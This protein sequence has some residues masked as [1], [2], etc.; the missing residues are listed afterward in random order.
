M[1]PL[2]YTKKRLLG[3]GGKTW[4]N[5]VARWIRERK[6]GLLPIRY[7]KRGILLQ[8]WGQ[9][10]LQGF[11]IRFIRHNALRGTKF[12]LCNV[13]ISKH[14]YLC[15]SISILLGKAL[16]GKAN[17]QDRHVA[18]GGTGQYSPKLKN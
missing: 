12:A 14:H 1:K 15:I 18:E 4:E 16:V 9:E 13:T 3:G 10:M 11:E 6:M 7:V 17:F 8:D 5:V 2:S